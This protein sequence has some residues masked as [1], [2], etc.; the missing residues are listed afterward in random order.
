[1]KRIYSFGLFCALSLSAFNVAA[2]EKSSSAEMDAMMKNWKAYMT[3]G[4]AHKLMASWDGT[5][6]GETTMWMEP[7]APPTKS[8]GTAVN[9]MVLGGR[10]QTST[11]KGDMMGM[12]FEGMG[13]MGYDNVKKIFVS[14]WIDNMGTGVM[15]MEGSWNEA[16]K[17]LSLKGKC[18]DPSRTDGKEMEMREVLRIIDD[19][20][21][22]M[23]MYSPGPDG[24]EY[25]MMEIN[26]TKS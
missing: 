21:H 13:T 10:Y 16:T 14:T 3:P 19:K 26:F 2:Q 6:N 11:H 24:K 17:T 15:M 23:E 1:M 7:G 5:W 20:H 18:V 4:E 25:K 12:P 9:K 22:V 8:K